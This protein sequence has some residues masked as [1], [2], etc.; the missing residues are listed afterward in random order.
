LEKS[1]LFTDHSAKEILKGSAAFCRA[2]LKEGR[3]NPSAAVARP[4]VLRKFL[5]LFMGILG[6]KMKEGSSEIKSPN[7]PDKF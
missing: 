7:L 5:L 6:L 1:R 2:K 3:P 4:V